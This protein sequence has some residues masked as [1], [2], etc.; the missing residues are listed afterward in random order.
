MSK[1][2]TPGRFAYVANAGLGGVGG[3]EQAP[4]T[5]RLWRPLTYD[6]WAAQG[7]VVLVGAVVV[8]PLRQVTAR[9]VGARVR[10]GY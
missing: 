3:G 2:W 4:R 5:S 10:S 8:P 6:K 1:G 9:G 7:R